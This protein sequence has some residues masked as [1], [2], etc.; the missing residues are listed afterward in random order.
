MNLDLDSF[1]FKKNIRLRYIVIVTVIYSVLFAVFI[2][3]FNREITKSYINNF[4]EITENNTAIITA[5]VKELLASGSG[6][7]FSKIITNPDLRY[8][9]D[10]GVIKTSTKTSVFPEDT[11]EEFLWFLDSELNQIENITSQNNKFSVYLD[12]K[13]DETREYLIYWQDITV[14]NQDYQKATLILGF[15]TGS[16]WLK[17]KNAQKEI[18]NVAVIIFIVGFIIIVF[19]ICNFVRPI[20]EIITFSENL[21]SGNFEKKITWKREDELGQLADTLNQMTDQIRSNINSLLEINQV[22][23]EISTVSEENLIGRHL[24]KN[25]QSIFNFDALI[26]GILLEDKNVLD[27]RF[28]SSRID[29]NLRV[30]K[31]EWDDILFEITQN[32]RAYFLVGIDK[33]KPIFE[34]LRRFHNKKYKSMLTVPIIY[35]DEILGFVMMLNKNEVEFM[36]PEINYLTILANQ[37]SVTIIN[38]RSY[39]VIQGLITDLESKVRQRTDELVKRNQELENTLTEL[40]ETQSQL[41]QSSKMAAL[42][43]LIA[44]IAHEINSPLGSINA[45]TDIYNRIFEIIQES[46][47]D[48][49]NEHQ[50]NKYLKKMRELN[51]INTEASRRIIKIVSGL[52]NFARTDE[53]EMRVANINDCILSTLTII[54]HEI[55]N[56]ITMKKNLGN[57][58]DILCYPDELNQVFMNLLINSIQAIRGVGVIKIHTKKKKNDIMIEIEDDGIG[59]DSKHLGKIFDPGYTTKGVGVGTGLGL[60][61]T[62]KIIE[63]HNGTIEVESRKG[64]GTKF[65][66]KIPIEMGRYERQENIDS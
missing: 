13:T 2:L 55:K 44:G 57:I 29:K 66:I 21:A 5:Q 11:P 35:A 41:I 26:T 28:N 16:T 39:R 61:I 17:I 54:R 7:I 23:R 19:L 32:N 51:K 53:S 46:P 14:H 8:R 22:S 27:I 38:A 60:S 47:Q 33:S 1:L 18:F 24:Y 31:D 10:I 58:P 42:G 65:T 50:L 40:N 63:K 34:F 49:L 25:I 12:R 6:N 48:N 52:K 43:Q 36:A 20:K 59:I 9:P 37:V 64:I 4:E 3:I 15:N 30:R 62:Y 56:R 45:N